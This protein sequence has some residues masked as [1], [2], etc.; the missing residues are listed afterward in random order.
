MNVQKRL[1]PTALLAV[2]VAVVSCLPGARAPEVTPT[3]TLELAGEPSPSTPSHAFAVVFASPTGTQVEASEVTI[4]FNR[5]MHPFEIAGQESKPPATLVMRGADRTPAGS[6]R[7]MGTSALVFAPDPALPAATEFVVTVP[8]G[9]RAMSGET[10]ASPYVFT[11][12]TPAPRLVRSEP[13]EGSDHLAPATTF[14]LG[15]NQ[16]VEPREVERAT[17]LTVGEGKDARKIAVHASRPKPDDEKL[18]KLVPASPLPLAS[19]VSLVVDDTLRGLEGPLPSGKK[20]ELKLATYGPLTARVHCY[21]K[22]GHCSPWESFELELSNGVRFDAI[23][24][25][26]R[27][28]PPAPIGWTRELEG[29]SQD[30][31]YSIP[32]RTRPG[33]TY[34]VTVTAGLRDEYGQTLAHDSVTTLAV[35]DLDPTVV[36]GVRGGVAEASQSRA[37]VVPVA[38][39]NMDH[40]TLATG[41]LDEPTLARLL[42]E[43]THESPST[44]LDVVSR[45]SGVKV[46]TVAS[47]APRNARFVKNVPLEP[48]LAA[49][50]GRGAVVLATESE[51]SF[52]GVT[53]LAMSAKM[54]RFGSVVWVTRLSDGKPVPGAT[55]AVFDEHG[56]VFDARTDADGIVPIPADAYAPADAEGRI[57]TTRIVVARLG[58]DWTWRTPQDEATWGGRDAWVDPAGGLE[59]MGMLFTDRGVY[60]PGETIKL[61]SIFR[62]PTP[63]GTDTPGGRAIDVKATDGEGNA[64]FEGK[65]TL[66]PFG[67]ATLDVPVPATAHLGGAEIRATL[68]GGASGRFEGT[69]TT[70]QLAAYKA[71]EFEVHV[72]PAARSWTHGDEARFDVRGDYLFGAPMPTAPVRWTVTRA[73]ASFTPPGAADFITSDEAF[74]R[75]LPDA[76]PRGGEI[77]SGNGALDSSG[78]LAV[79]APLALPGQRGAESVTLEAEVTD[80]TR[81]TSAARASAIVH[82]ASFYVALKEPRDWFVGA[83]DPV[84]AEVA[85]LDPSGQRR[86]GVG[87]HVELVRRTWKS[88]VETGSDSR[89]HW[90]STPVNTTV[91]ICDVTTTADPVPCA[92]STSQPGYYFVHASARD[93]KGRSVASSYDVYLLGDSGDASWRMGDSAELQLVPDK[94]SYVA[95]DVARVLVKSPFREAEALVTVER[96]GVYRQQRV[97]LAGPMPTVTVPVT[98]DMRPN[99]FV[100]VEL[101][102]GRTK[103]APATGADVGAPAYKSGYA[104]IIVDPESRRLKVALT[105]SKKEL[106]PGE[107]VDVDVVVTDRAGKPAPSELTLWAVDEGVLML[108]GYKTPD[109]LPAFTGPRPLAVWGLESRADLARFFRPDVGQ[110]G[111]DKGDPGGGGGE[112]MRAD[113]RATAWFQPSVL[114]GVDGRA[115]TR[116]KLPDN[117][118]T[119]RVM[120]VA[121]ARDDRFGAADTQV[122]TSR[123]LMLRPALPRF[124][125]AGDSMD[126]GVVVTSKQKQDARVEVTLAAEGVIVGADAKRTVDVKA[127]SSVEVRWPM[128]AERGGKAK[129]GFRARGGGESDA[130]E[131]TRRVDVPAVL[132]TVA[133]DGETREA[134]AEKLGELGAIRDDVGQLDVRL[135]STALVGV[136][137]GMDQ[138]IEY[139]YGCTEQLTSRLVPLVA[140]RRLANDFGVSLGKDPDGLADAAV[141]KILANQRG[142]GGFGYWPDSRRSDAW[143]TAYALWGLDIAKKGGRPVPADAMEHAAGWLRGELGRLASLDRVGIAAGTFAVDVLAT[144]GKPD[145]GFTNRLYDRRADLPLFARALLAHA[146]AV[147]S[148]DASQ[149]AELM[150]DLDA[151][152]RITPTQA[153]VVAN[154]GDEYAPVLDSEPRTTAM[155]LRALV[156]MDPKHVLL[157][158][159]ARGLLATRDRGR[160]ESTQEAAWAL[161]SLDDYR[162]AVETDIPDFDGRVWLSGELA[163]DAPF[164]GRSAIA[165]DA[166][167]PVAK[168]LAAK[169]P[170]IAFQVDGTGDL[171]YE[172]RLR[173]ARKEMPRDDLDRGFFVRKLVRGV[174]P[175][176]LKQALATLPGESQT[177]VAPGDLVL[178]DLMVV[179]TSPREQVVVDDPLPAGLEPVDTTLETTARSLDVADTGGQGEADDASRSDDDARAAGHAWSFAWFHR[180]MHDDR[181]LTFVEHM[182]V[183]MFHYRYLARATTAGK[184]VVP[185]TRAE[186]MYQPEVFGRTGATALEVKVP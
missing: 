71:S 38:S 63:R 128:A 150:R 54:S 67:E 110:V 159:L 143:V 112:P 55:I 109:P 132:E 146:I 60:R 113:F 102:R 45:T 53:D 179:T 44:L 169:Q 69:S 174:A 66:D 94:K 152:L 116:F 16:R 160:W 145:P 22:D 167:L 51:T 149:S 23:K 1:M 41:A 158:K 157:S 138:L 21:G 104:R 93:E 140:V 95:G 57:D 42:A 170:T 135:A 127:G 124:L 139:P 75:E 137:D 88:V 118:T 34:R 162:R 31:S 126:A 11:F 17:A 19:R 133:L 181:V 25:H 148:M 147:S 49:H 46:E 33:T 70:V 30:S 86:A 26:V 97:H 122:T 134:A 151:H 61:Q 165:R 64:V 24:G 183:G 101:V 105:T 43:R 74:Q 103:A 125:R 2:L 131:V 6:W 65:A 130:V 115:H 7:W 176:D 3:R 50:G 5:A 52:L 177:R 48:L 119:F 108:T 166:Q 83:N 117:L 32:A 114:T 161:V 72:D 163:L 12:A 20:H 4:V 35:D 15:F 58:D 87:V 164:R 47:G 37:R 120:A 185:P 144:M 36:T 186:C 100:G 98:E 111:L 59:P 82:P 81:Q 91:A 168:L 27:V 85:A 141:A 13:S 77:Q 184:F 142:D 39:V 28:D 171:F 155:A 121:V 92:L 178:V 154:L 29:G 76:A 62:L 180:E 18:V 173:Y 80:V 90:E 136:S 8:A 89:G 40:Y 73:Q 99:V 175:A 182:P 153:T 156:A 9:T 123:P 172:A 107:T 129:L 14:Q 56:S 79:R 78:A 68:S 96:T 84:R 106:R 10:L